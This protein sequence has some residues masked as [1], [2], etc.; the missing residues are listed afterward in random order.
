MHTIIYL[1]ELTV[2]Y[3]DWVPPK[4]TCT[5]QLLCSNTGTKLGLGFSVKITV[6]VKRIGLG[7]GLRV[8]FRFRFKG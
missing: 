7:L 5:G 1:V 2:V 6:R 3:D 4:K 8:R